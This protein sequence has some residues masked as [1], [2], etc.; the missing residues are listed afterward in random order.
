MFSKFETMVAFRYLRSKKREA[1][2]SVIA[3]FS[4][5]GV[6]L[7]V[8]ALIVVMAVMNGFHKEISSKMSGFNG[9]IIVKTFRGYIDDY[10][11]I[12][13][14]IRTIDDVV[15]ASPVIEGQVMAVHKNFN[16][17]AL[18]KGMKLSDLK[19]K[20]LVAKHII[21][22]D[23]DSLNDNNYILLGYDLADNLRVMAG[24][25]VMLI[26]PQGT[27]TVIGMVPRIKTFNAGA[28]FK[29]DMYAYD[30]GTIFMNLEMAQIY[31]RLKNR[32]NI[33]EVMIKDPHKSEEVVEK[34]SALIG[35]EYSINDWKTINASY[36]NVLKTER[37]VMFLILTLIIIVAAFNIIS[38]LM[39]LVNDKAKDIAILRTM[40]A[41][42]GAILRIF[43]LCGSLVGVAGTAIGVAIGLLFALNIDSIRK[44]LEKVSGNTIFDPI[45]Y[46]LSSL[47]S[48]VQLNDVLLVAI[49]SSGLAF[50]A[51]IYPARKAARTEPVEGLRYE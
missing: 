7:G 15:I 18:V 6:A 30:V 10:D 43:F 47:P 32:V 42:R 50:M 17:G 49:L 8:A 22:G 40:G 12:A 46:Y 11:V 48:D 3:G 20:S 14:K 29:S 36:F 1:I 33:I 16:M 31:F 5:I 25:P 34:I 26:S 35:A 27:S 2:V 38:S 37:V 23:I 24:D 45:V 28:L 41:S 44:L 4:L 19:N 51:T 9:D 13:D 21:Q 39:M